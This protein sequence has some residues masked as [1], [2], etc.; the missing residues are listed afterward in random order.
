MNVRDGLFLGG[1]GLA[2]SLLAA[3]YLLPDARPRAVASAVGRDPL[4]VGAVDAAFRAA[5]DAAGVEPTPVASELAQMRRLS[6]ALTGSIPSLEEIRR[7]EARPAGRRLEPWLD[8]I[9]RDRRS[10]DYLAERLARAYVGTEDGQFLL[11]RRRRFTTWLSDALLANRPYD[12][13]VRDLIASEGLWTAEPA[14]NF[15]TGAYSQ[16][17][18]RPD[19]EKL[20]IR[21]S[22]CFLGVRLDCAQC[23]DHPFREWKQRDFRGLAAF[24]GALHSDLRGIR[25]TENDYRPND[26]ATERPGPLVEPAVPFRGELLAAGEAPRARLAAWL[27]D[28]RNPTLARATVNRVWALMFGR[29]L[30]DP[31]DDLPPEDEQ[32]E[33]LVLLAEDFAA[34]GYDLRRLLRTIATSAPFRLDSATGVAEGPTDLQEAHWS[35]FPLTP[36]RPEQSAES[37]IQCGGLGTIGPE[38][39]WPARLAA[40]T[41]R[42]DFVRRYGD[43][44]EDEFDAPGGTIPQRLLLMNGELVGEKIKPDLF[45]SSTRIAAQA[46][47]DRSA[48]EVA[49]LTILTRRPTPEES[50]H[51]AARLE[52][53]IGDARAERVSDLFWTLLNSSE[54][55]W[56]H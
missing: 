27:G 4:A 18:E 28:R 5:W 29:P 12:Q 39:A 44:G 8:E 52:G 31:V 38:S 55:A 51:F 53:T 32:P 6:L 15:I 24:F 40:F 48:V 1:L 10:A 26:P 35:S 46:P 45:T 41:G 2:V 36:L 20:A 22:R 54:F 49:Y 37:V 14:T 16:E 56:N 3:R 50:A 21:V 11:F 34:H 43:L 7:F 19:P 42:N 13:I 23:H 9:L 25:D 47:D 30:S 17:T 33:A